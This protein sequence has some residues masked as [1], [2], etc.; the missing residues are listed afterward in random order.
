MH[1]GSTLPIE[2][3]ARGGAARVRRP[4]SAA[5]TP[6]RA[7]QPSCRNARRSGRGAD[8][9]G[10]D[11][12]HQPDRAGAAR[13][14]VARRE[15]FA[16][17]EAA[18]RDAAHHAPGAPPRSSRARACA[19]SSSTSSRRD[20]CSAGRSPACSTRSS[21]GDSWCCSPRSRRGSSK[22][23]G[24]DSSSTCS[25]EAGRSRSCRTSSSSS[26]SAA[27]SLALFNRLVINPTRFRGSH[28]GDAILILAWIGVLLVCMELNYA[29][30]I[31]EGAPEALG[32]WRPIAVGAREHLPP[33]RLR[34][35]GADRPPRDLLLG[36][37]HARLRI[38]RLP[39]LQQA[40][41]HHHVGSQRLLQERASRKA[42]CARS[43]S[44][45]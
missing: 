36:A 5:R 25:R 42:R 40:P 21:S 19:R 6:P 7:S 10:R 34:Q 22:R 32:Q 4:C 13:R 45:R 39:R 44:R 20:G 8:V 43:T 12:D 17:A 33:A 30:R 1:A 15:R 24:R 2:R 38:P 23:S 28:R 35:R 18:R 14:R 27:S 31:A 37:P 16:L 29:T 26:S 9:R 41:A 11:R 3:R